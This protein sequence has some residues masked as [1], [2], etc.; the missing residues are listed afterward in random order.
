MMSRWARDLI[1]GARLAWAGGRDGWIRAVMTAVGVGIGVAMLLAA[2]SIPN[3]QQ[4]RHDRTVARD[5]LTFHEPPLAKSGRTLVVLPVDT[6][7]RTTRVSGLALQADG[8]DAP[9]PPGVKALPRPGEMVV[10]PALA[11]LL[12]ST[13]G[14]LLKP[15]LPY[16][17]AGTIG[18][19]GLT[20][21]REYAFYLGSDQL[22]G[23]PDANRIDQFGVGRTDE[24]LSPMLA[25]LVVIIF[26][27]LLLPI[28]V[29]IAAAIRFGDERR[30]RR[31][32]AL[33]LVGADSRM[34]RR[35]A[36]GEA[37]I[38][39]ALGVLAG[40]A[41]FLVGTR[42]VERITLLDLSVFTSDVRPDPVFATLIVLAVPAAAVAVTVL[43]MSRIVIE[44]LGV[45]RRTGSTRRRLWWRL[46]PPVVGLALL[47]PLVG[48]VRVV[49]AR[50]NPYQVATG[51]VLLLISVAAILPWLIE[52]VVRR[53]GGGPVAWQLAVRRLQLGSGTAAR[54]VN[55]IAV[56]VAGGIALQMLFAAAAAA[57]SSRTGQDTVRAQVEA[58]LERAADAA[59]AQEIAAKFRATQGVRSAYSIARFSGTDPAP[60]PQP[61]SSS[62]QGNTPPTFGL[63]VGDCPALAEVAAIDR[64]ADG[65][66]FLVANP[67]GDGYQMATPA[68]GRRVRIGAAEWTVPGSAQAAQP[69]RDA[70]GQLVGGVF[71]T[72]SAAGVAAL[73]G[74]YVTALLRVDQAK[75]DV[76]EYVRNTAFGIS[77]AMS[78][79]ILQA[80]R[81]SSRFTDIRRGLFIGLVVTLLLIGASLLVSTLEQLQERRRLLAVLVA[82]GT[83]RA[84]LS[85]SVLWQTAVPVLLGLGLAV[86]TG[87]GLGAVLLAMVG[88]RVRFD[89]LSMA[90]VAGV[91]SA[92]VLLVTALSLPALWRLM[93][94]E[95][96]R[97]E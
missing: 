18:D 66:V 47:Y 26:V 49:G 96:L 50:A 63:F 88:E 97:T 4:A 10:S 58:G 2:S 61:P 16:R 41:F 83:R 35:T 13:D 44:P 94:P 7:F 19:R 6:T 21:P 11:K 40:A 5:Y 38:T 76:Y 54:V 15:R 23:N 29:F 71:A 3:V 91:G 22:A 36:A 17:I 42:F 37:L 86:V 57:S 75:P 81:E 65:D 52:A 55:G 39:A 33:R 28:G 72:P 69:R 85:W 12:S 67:I 1:L 84:T 60:P 93:R 34:A 79:S 87:G 46:A 14:A 53:L 80:E 68:P 95:A 78:V 70:L 77:P 73:R 56:A 48:G 45:V 82:L 59:S 51:A 8:P 25:L 31:L 89:W 20:G 74:P 90:G 27:V 32:A 92:V 62:S 9:V 64:C 24:V 30:D 43:A